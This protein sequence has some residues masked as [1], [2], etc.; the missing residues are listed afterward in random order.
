[1]IRTWAYCI[2][3]PTPRETR[4]AVTTHMVP[5]NAA[6]AE[7]DWWTAGTIYPSKAMLNNL[8]PRTVIPT[9]PSDI[10]TASTTCQRYG[11]RYRISRRVM[12]ES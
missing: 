5:T 4:N 10:D 7:I 6:C 1:M 11:Q 3:K 9:T 2:P 12:R 8:G